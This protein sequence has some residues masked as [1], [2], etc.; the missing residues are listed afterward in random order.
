M[1]N[2]QKGSDDRMIH[3]L[4]RLAAS[5]LLMLEMASSSQDLVCARLEKDGIK[6]LGQSVGG[7]ATTNRIP[8]ITIKAV[9]EVMLSQKNTTP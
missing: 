1:P 2:R 6:K 8:A 5:Q 7:N 4:L 3:D 9:A